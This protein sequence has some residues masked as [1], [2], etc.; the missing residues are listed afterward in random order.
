MKLVQYQ[1][2]YASAN[3]H[4]FF[5]AKEQF[6]NSKHRKRF[7]KE[8][9]SQKKIL[10]VGGMREIYSLLIINFQF[11]FLSLLVWKILLKVEHDSRVIQN[12]AQRDNGDL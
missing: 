7:L 6:S 2:I 11:G 1:I 12:G 5:L 3:T 9:V 4:D 10:N 8:N